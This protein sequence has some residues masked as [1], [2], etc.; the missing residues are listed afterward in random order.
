MRDGGKRG[1]L[2]ETCGWLTLTFPGPTRL[3]APLYPA[4]CSVTP[5]CPPLPRIPWTPPCLVSD[6]PSPRQLFSHQIIGSLNSLCLPLPGN[7]PSTPSSSPGGKEDGPEPRPAGAD[8]DAPSTD[9]ADSASVV[10]EIGSRDMGWELVWRPI[11][12]SRERERE[13]RNG[14]GQP[15]RLADFFF[16]C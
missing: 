2:I 4:G 7:G 8:P 12:E 9:G 1:T 15:Q 13:I 16:F 11:E 10:G 3:S 14:D 5:P 6:P